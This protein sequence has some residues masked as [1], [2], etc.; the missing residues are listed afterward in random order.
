LELSA[1]PR[2]SSI[3]G[4]TPKSRLFGDPGGE[5]SFDAARSE[6]PRVPDEEALEAKGEEGSH[7]LP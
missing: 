6:Q 7:L 4:S 3:E 1:K 5:K 2:K